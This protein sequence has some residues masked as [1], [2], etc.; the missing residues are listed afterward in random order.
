MAQ[1][2]A[3]EPVSLRPEEP[4]PAV[5]EEK[6]DA[7]QTIGRAMAKAQE[8]KKGDITV[9]IRICPFELCGGAVM[10]RDQQILREQQLEVE[11]KAEDEKEK[12][13]ATA[14]ARQVEK[15][16]D[17]DVEDLAQEA[18]LRR[19][20]A[21]AC[22][23]IESQIEEKTIDP[24]SLKVCNTPA[25]PRSSR[26]WRYYRPRPLPARSLAP[27]PLIRAAPRR[28]SRASPPPSR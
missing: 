9:A 16:G 20:S 15:D 2:V 3:Q 28:R 21:G 25:G 17:E 13:R 10:T 18:I 27:P 6:L 24:C 11:R 7:R 8:G 1:A 22:Q 19:A 26:V 4:A 23:S 5:V 12:E 14:K